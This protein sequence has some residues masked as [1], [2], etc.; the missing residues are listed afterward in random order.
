MVTGTYS[1]AWLYTIWAALAFL[2]AYFIS[3][4]LVYCFLCRPLTAYWES[5]DFAYDKPY[6]CINGNVLN[7]FIGALSVFTDVY[8]VVIPCVMLA[9]VELDV[10]RRQRIGLNIIFA[11]GLV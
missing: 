9:H 7:P 4:L 6:T 5:Y 10:P 1:R 3:I 8:A 11:L 2:W